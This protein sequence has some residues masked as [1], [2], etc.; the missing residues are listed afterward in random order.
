LNPTPLPKMGDNRKCIN[1]GRCVLGCAYCAK[2]DSRSYLQSAVEKGATVLTGRRV[3]Q[4]VIKGSMAVG[5][6]A[7]RGWRTEFHAAD[8]V[9]LA[10]GGFG[11]PEILEN[12]GIA[13]EKRLFIDP[14]LC[15]AAEWRGAN[16]DQE[17]SMPFVVE[18]DGYILAPYFDY[19]SFFFNNDWRLPAN[20][21]LSIMIKLADSCSGTITKGKIIKTLTDQDQERLKTA[22]VVCQEI[23]GRLGIAADQTF[24]GTINAGHPGGMMPLTEQEAETFHHRQLPENLYLA[25]SSLFPS[26][27]GKPPI[28]TIM[29]MAKRVAKICAQL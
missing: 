8:L 22:V 14:V 16:Q 26:S 12:S 3:S 21:I 15:V 4:V 2:W 17:L 23:F 6:K 25:D 1:C 5:V 29:A 10:A 27:L 19:L 13:S 9:V 7:S 24:L 18:K 28:L 11:T 20:D